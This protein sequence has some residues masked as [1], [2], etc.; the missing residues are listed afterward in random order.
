MSAINETD[1]GDMGNAITGSDAE[2]AINAL[3]ARRHWLIKILASS[4]PQTK[5]PDHDAHRVE[6]WAQGIFFIDQALIS[7]TARP[8]DD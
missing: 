7:L 8:G 1:G 5:L 2:R 6:G 4:K 3:R